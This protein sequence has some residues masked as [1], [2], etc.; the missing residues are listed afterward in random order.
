M[1]K[2]ILALAIVKKG[3]GGQS[4]DDGLYNVESG[5]A[6]NLVDKVAISGPNGKMIASGEFSNDIR[7][8]YYRINNEVENIQGPEIS[9]GR[10]YYLWGA[11]DTGL[12]NREYVEPGKYYYSDG[13]SNT[14]LTE[15]PAPVT[16][17]GVYYPS[18]NGPVVDISQYA[19]LG[20]QY[21]E[22]AN[23]L[24][25]D[26]N[27][28]NLA[29]LAAHL[30]QHFICSAPVIVRQNSTLFFSISEFLSAPVFEC[31]WDGSSLIKWTYNQEADFLRFTANAGAG[32]L[33]TWIPCSR[34][35]S[36]EMLIITVNRSDIVI[37]VHSDVEVSESEIRE[38]LQ[39]H[40]PLWTQC[41]VLKVFTITGEL[42]DTIEANEECSIQIE[43]TPVSN[44][45]G[46]YSY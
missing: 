3:G 30:Q 45:N 17:S 8:M 43:Q 7:A 36:S 20:F 35:Y 2:D 32:V 12:I 40:A 10:A 18:Y 42:L 26:N 33:N 11:V 9:N 28:D 14:M 31:K 15:I 46:D 24:K 25:Y 39:D 23:D 21:F 38:Y 34:V 41:P 1:R 6:T 44:N 19:Y 5:N 13:H 29:L 27:G 22:V 37:L 4:L 16:P